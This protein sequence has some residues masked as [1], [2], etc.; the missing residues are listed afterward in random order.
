MK[1]VNILSL[2][3]ERKK[4]LRQ[5]ADAIREKQN[6]PIE[7]LSEILENTP[8]FLGLFR[9]KKRKVSISRL[10]KLGIIL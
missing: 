7:G 5:L 9:R 10:T 8:S 2:S 3:K 6:M 4:E 1:E